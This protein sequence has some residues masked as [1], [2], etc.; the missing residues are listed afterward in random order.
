M[1]KR[2]V[3]LT[4]ERILNLKPAATRLTV[5]DP[6]LPGLAIRVQPSGHKTFVF[7]ARYPRSG[8]FT[9]CELGQV[10][11][12]TLEEARTKARRWAAWIAAGVD[13]RDEEAKLRRAAED[14][15]ALAVDNS[16]AV[17]AEAF[18]A[19][20][21]KGKRKAKVVEREIRNEV[22]SRLGA[23][24]VTEITR[25]DV[26]DLIEK[27]ADRPAPA[28]AR[29]ILGHI[30]T[31]F[32]WAINR[33]IYGLQGSPCDRLKPGQLIGPKVNRERVLNDQELRTLWAA[34]DEV[35]Y[36]F[37]PATKM[38]M[39]TGARLNEV[40]G[41]RWSEFDDDARL[42]TVPAERFKMNSQHFIPITD[43]VA[44]LL[45]TVPQWTQG[46]HL[47]STTSGEKPLRFHD[48]TVAKLRKAVGAE[49][50]WTLHDIR[51]TVR[52][53]LSA[54][55]VPEPVAEMV[56]GHSRRGMS[57]IYDQH[58]Y[59]DE[60]REALQAW[61][62]LLRGIVEPPPPNVVPLGARKAR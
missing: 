4:D 22:M 31:L 12:L 50:R 7:G 37:G 17:V 1:P 19:R 54:L 14:A 60:M 8:H 5:Y 28:H 35:G 24:P 42:W 58:Q 47:F 33:D 6:A 61:G 52:T 21:L 39:L 51:R 40:M 45:A 16:L 9:R 27:I 41:A 15:A 36:P 10:G 30:R 53:R 44:T 62:M 23:R 48:G 46:D 55:R 26:V 57:R 34:A 18:I 13:P 43:E 56:I 38:L 20:H 32:N 29:N 2:I 3:A 25:R 59:L 11:R 49:L